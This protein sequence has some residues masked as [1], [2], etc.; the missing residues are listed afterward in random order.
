MA[1]IALTQLKRLDFDNAYRRQLATWYKDELKNL[2][3]KVKFIQ[4]PSECESSQHLFQII[5]DDRDKLM[6]DLRSNEIFPGV[7]YV[8]NT[9]YRMYQYAQG[10]CPNSLHISHHI[11]SLPLHLQL[12]HE[13]IKIIC[14]VIKASLGD[15]S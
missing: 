1:A 6:D 13:E 3:G 2:C 10:N 9:E 7:H 12:R 4:I 15:A 14:R 11:L 8:D 5:V